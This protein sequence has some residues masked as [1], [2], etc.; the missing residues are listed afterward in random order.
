[1]VPV[2]KI[3][4]SLGATVYWDNVPSTII[5]GRTPATVRAISESFGYKVD[6]LNNVRKYYNTAR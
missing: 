3:F 1:M 4:E 6:W 2:R 5:E